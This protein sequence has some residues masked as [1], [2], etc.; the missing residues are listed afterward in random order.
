[1]ES[2]KLEDI[3]QLSLLSTER[4][5]ERSGVLN[6]GVLEGGTVR[7]LIIKYSGSLEGLRKQGIE[8]EELLAGYA[9]V[10]LP[11]EQVGSLTDFPEVEYVEMPKNLQTGLY[12]AKRV[13]C[14]LPLT[15]GSATGGRLSGRGVLVAVLD[16]G[17]DFFLQDFRNVDGSSRIVFLWDQELEREFSK[18]ELDRALAEQSRE[19]A[20]EKIPSI[21][22][23]TGRQWRR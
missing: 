2:E 9:V 7:E 11:E 10:R 22:R 6:V 21:A 17:I 20:Y 13:S 18:E 12:E 19:A 14:I 1:M 4:Q 16:S 23:G 3:L 8:V 5:R 15:Q